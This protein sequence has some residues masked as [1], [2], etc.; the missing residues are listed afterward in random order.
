MN[1]NEPAVGLKV[2][3]SNL[4]APALATQV[5]YEVVAATNNTKSIP[6]TPFLN[7]FGIV[8]VPHYPLKNNF[9]DGYT[10]LSCK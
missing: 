7:E 10:L 9:Y 5:S 6:F 3:G 1:S 4:H 2:V 8:T